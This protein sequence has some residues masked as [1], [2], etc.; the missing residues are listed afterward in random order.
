[1]LPL[2]TIFA[3]A[4][5]WHLLAFAAGGVYVA[6]SYQALFNGGYVP[7]WGRVIRRADWHLWAS[8]LGVIGLGIAL[9]GTDRFVSDPKLWAKVL[10][11]A[12]WFVSTQV[13]R[14]LDPAKHPKAIDV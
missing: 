8:G 14:R 10:V 6:L 1:M 3:F 11:I 13:L 9:A 2:Q 4:L 7:Q 5:F 12:V